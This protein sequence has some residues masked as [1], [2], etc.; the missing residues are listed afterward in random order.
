MKRASAR[1]A[2]ALVAVLGAGVLPGAAFGTPA[3]A[4]PG[5]AAARFWAE[6]FGRS[7]AQ[8]AN[9]SARVR[10]DSRYDPRSAVRTSALAAWISEHGDTAIVQY[11]SSGKAA[12]IERAKVGGQRNLDFAR[13][14]MQTHLPEYSPN[15]HAAAKTAV[16]GGDVE[17]EH[18]ARTGY[19]AAKELDQRRHRDQVAKDE[20]MTA[21]D[22]EFVRQR[23]LSDPGAQVR[24]AA[25]W[26]LRTGSTD[27]DIV[28]FLR[29]DWISAAALDRDTYRVTGAERDAQTHRQLAELV[30]AARA[31]EAAEAAASEEMREQAKAVTK[32]AWGA[33][34][35]AAKRTEAAWLA[36]AE[37]SAEQAR[38]WQNIAAHAAAQLESP[39]WKSL[40]S[41]ARANQR[42]WTDDQSWAGEQSRY[43]AGQAAEA[44]AKQNR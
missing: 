22:R 44:T 6:E 37:R 23:A 7:A 10:R 15:V 5:A 34:A 42:G 14:V 43:W 39:T 36:E 25:E 30:T 28:E 18:F 31:A 2:C 13:R 35:E 41:P 11:L 27:A 20:Q 4:G 38:H 26:A 32:R 21:A 33:A 8:V 9:D 24:A 16:N 17:R 3:D 29:F 1:C 12:A 19:A 40:A